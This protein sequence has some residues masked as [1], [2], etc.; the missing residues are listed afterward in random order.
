MQLSIKMQDIKV[1][2]I[3][4]IYQPIYHLSHTEHLSSTNTVSLFL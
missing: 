2:K 4:I 1:F 3:N